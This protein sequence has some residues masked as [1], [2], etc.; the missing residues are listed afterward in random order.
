MPRHI[1]CTRVWQAPV[2]EPPPEI[3]QD[4]ETLKI[5]K[6]YQPPGKQPSGNAAQIPGSG[7]VKYMKSPI[8]VSMI[9]YDDL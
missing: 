6:N 9:F 1:R 2:E 3:E 4:D 8:T 7:A 5:I